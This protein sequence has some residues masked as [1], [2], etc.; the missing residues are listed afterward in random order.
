M[1]TTTAVDGVTAATGP[2]VDG[3]GFVAESA[4]AAAPR[5]ASSAPTADQA[6]LPSSRMPTMPTMVAISRPGEP[7]SDGGAG[8]ATIRPYRSEAPPVAGCALQPAYGFCDD[9]HWP[10]CSPASLAA[11]L[12]WRECESST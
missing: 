10:A 5:A 12:L 11:S 9:I 6:R 1:V 8:R 2:S 7:S 3:G 4:D